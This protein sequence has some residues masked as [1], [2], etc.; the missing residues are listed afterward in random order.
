MTPFDAKLDATAKRTERLLD[1]LLSAEVQPQETT[2]PARLL[3]AM[4]YGALNG[5]KRLRP[6]LVVES[7]ALF[8]GDETAALR[9]GAALECLHSYSLVHDDLPAMDD[10]DLRRG[11]PTV[12]IAF[13]EATAIL[14]GDALLTY[15]FDI[16]AAPETDLPDRARIELVLALS[17]AAGLGG[18]AGG[19]ALDLAAEKETPDEPGIV[20]LQAMKTGALIRFA[21]EAGA[22]I[23][24]APAEDRD[25]MRRFGEIIGRA[26]QLADDLLD[27]TSDAATLG[28]AAGKDAARGKGT[29]VALKGQPWAE[30]E[31]D[32]LVGEATDLIAAYGDRARTLVEAAR[33]VANRK[34]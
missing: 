30:A 13:D 17:R 8:G 15:A 19:Q 21:C 29:L 26:F 12:H 5:G 10:D 22:I 16:I 7:A 27:L 14:A 20:T 1:Q 4:H 9:V 32:R 11:K 33:F 2:R 34:N 25:R 24:G 3:Q 18:M 23:G 6:F 31:L 28:K